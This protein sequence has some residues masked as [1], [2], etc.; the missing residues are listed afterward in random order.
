M[1]EL[2]TKE[3]ERSTILLSAIEGR[4]TNA[5]AAKQLGV[6]VRQVQR[7]KAN[8]RQNGTSGVIHKLKGKPSNHSLPASIKEQALYV[9][10]E[11]YADFKPTFAT[12]KLAE[13]HGIII[14]PETARLWMIE[15]GL[16]EKHK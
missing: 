4:I 7:A 10:K 12:E 8:M 5:A 11:K 3:Q 2:T 6:S 16:W 1:S 15:Q 13:N 14:N 9:I